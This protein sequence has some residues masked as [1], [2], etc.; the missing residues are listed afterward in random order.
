MKRLVLMLIIGVSCFLTSGC[1]VLSLNPFYTEE[2]KVSYTEIEGKWRLLQ[3]FGNDVSDRQINPWTFMGYTIESYDKE[4]V[5]ADLYVKYF[6]VNGT[7]FMD[8]MADEIKGANEYWISMVYPMH[9]LC[10]V[11]MEIDTLRLIPLNYDYDYSSLDHVQPFDDDSLTIITE[12]PEGWVEFLKQ[13]K[14]D[15][16]LFEEKLTTTLVKEHGD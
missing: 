14:D 6:E 5:H 11:E 9:V 10:R 1:L 3:S 15:D 4:N 7:I 13:Y 8:L 16:E 12:K 2:T